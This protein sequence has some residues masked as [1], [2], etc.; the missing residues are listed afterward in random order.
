M[1]LI[2]RVWFHIVY[3]SF[4][5]LVSQTA[6]AEVP[7][8]AYTGREFD[9]E[10]GLFYYRE[11]YYESTLGQFLSEDPLGF[12][13]GDTNLYRYVG[14][15]PLNATDPFGQSAWV[16]SPSH[17]TSGASSLIPDIRPHLPSRS[18]LGWAGL[19]LAGAAV[20]GLVMG[21]SRLRLSRDLPSAL[22]MPWVEQAPRPS[23]FSLPD[24]CLIRQPKRRLKT[25]KPS[26]TRI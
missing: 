8:F 5:N 20:A 3:D 10:I 18:R 4:G 7:R 22:F 25:H 17:Y 19:K 6:P 1:S 13:A 2:R 26:R 12:A 16:A 11:R 23:G 15:S 9:P 21:R 24:T 14:A